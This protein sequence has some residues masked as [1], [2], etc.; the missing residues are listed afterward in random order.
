M[1]VIPEE[2][3][4]SGDGMDIAPF[5]SLIRRLRDPGLGC[6]WDVSRTLENMAE[7]LTG[8]AEEA[9]E[10]LRQDDPPH[11]CEELGDVFLNVMLAVVIAEEKGLFTWKDV[12]T[13]VSEKLVRRHPHVF[14]EKAAHSPEQALKMF[15]E[16]KANEKQYRKG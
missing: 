9:A 2:F 13:G 1:T 6:P 3:R 12:I 4:P 10:A 5:H 7:S 11:Q 15:L 16:A 14:G 8:E